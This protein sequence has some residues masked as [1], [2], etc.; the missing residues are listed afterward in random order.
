MEI[1]ILGSSHGVPEK[2]RFCSAALITCGGKHYLVDAGAPV[3]ELFVNYDININDLKAVFL[4]HRHS[5]HTFGLAHLLDLGSWY[6]GESSFDSYFTEEKTLNGFRTFIQTSLDDDEWHEDRMRLHTYE[7]GTFYDD[8]NLKVTA[9]PTRHLESRGYPSYAFCIEGDGKRVVFT[10]DMHHGDPVDFPKVA[11]ELPCDAVFSELV[12]FHMDKL[13]PHI[14]KCDVK[15]F[16]FQHYNE[17]W[18]IREIK[19]LMENNELS[20]KVSFV[21]DGDKIIL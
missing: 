15:N 2:D 21:K 20:C 7:A 1:L 12:H 17:D 5:D 16:I 9:I 4:T 19:E 10:G 14:E 18:S 11:E 3:A 13:L 6:Y 8:G